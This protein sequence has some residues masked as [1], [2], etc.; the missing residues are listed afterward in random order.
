[1]LP[2]SPLAE[3]WI[4]GV[5]ANLAAP[6]EVLLRVLDPAGAPAWT[7]L[8]G[9]RTLPAEVVAAV[10]AHPDR[11]V[12]RAFARN[13]HVDPADRGRLALDPD[14]WVR[15][16]LACGPRPRPAQLRP[17]PD[18]ALE[19]LLL[20]DC[21]HGNSVL[22][23][24]EFCEEL[25]FSQQVPQDFL[26]GLLNHP[27][28]ALRRHS[29][30]AWRW[31]TDDERQ[32]LRA[33]Q[34]PG[35]RD[36]VRMMTWT[37]TEV[38]AEDIPEQDCHARL[39]RLL[40]CPLPRSVIESCFASGRDLHVLACNRHMPADVVARLAR[41]ASPEVRADVAHRSDL[42]PALLAELGRDPD[43]QVRAQIAN[44]VDLDPVLLGDLARD[45]NPRVRERVAGNPGLDP[46]L[47]D[48]LARDPDEDVRARAR[49]RPRATNEFHRRSISGAAGRRTADEIGRLERGA[50]GMD[51]DWLAACAA[52][53]HPLMRRI[54]AI[55]S[56]VLPPDLVDRLVHDLDQDVRH[57]LAYNHPDAPAELLLE[58]FLTGLRQRAFLLT[59]PAFPRVGLGGLLSHPDPEVRALAA[60][61]V[62]L[63]EPPYAQ[64]ADVDPR[65]R[66][67]AAANPL[68]PPDWIADLLDDPSLAEAAAANPALTS[69]QLHDLL[70]RARIPGPATA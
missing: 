15:I 21:V 68:L 14:D 65:V 33:D 11:V 56:D 7:V 19:R 13:G 34:D 41:D 2:S 64:L 60:A 36:T 70:D 1:M 46:A 44:H 54:A 8:C 25:F 26:R 16:S 49:L 3:S 5:A 67:A 51:T 6:P 20:Q 32:A 38:A 52:S 29:A 63:D 4:R 40:N 48:E 66:Q 37:D 12:R 58:A 22:R 69:E 10:L 50:E 28:P 57:L 24:G 30:R 61:D 42:D 45:P 27:N 35:V 59:L 31:L 43:P 53:A 17:L 47:L 39:D 23:A 55:H 18:D 9:Q 62:T